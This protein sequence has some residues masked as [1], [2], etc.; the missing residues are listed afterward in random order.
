MHFMIIKCLNKNNLIHALNLQQRFSQLIHSVN[1]IWHNM[2]H[3]VIMYGIKWFSA[4][5]PW[6][7]SR[8]TDPSP[9]PRGCLPCGWGLTT[10]PC[11]RRSGLSSWTAYIGLSLLWWTVEEYTELSEVSEMKKLHQDLKQLLNSLLAICNSVVNCQCRINQ[12][13][14]IL[15]IHPFYKK[16]YCVMNYEYNF[17]T[18]H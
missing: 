15:L 16:N 2:V 6:E 9:E 5:M 1:Y 18:Y 14:I 10:H 11:T 13:L 8:N 7:I 3:N 17:L 12:I 4:G